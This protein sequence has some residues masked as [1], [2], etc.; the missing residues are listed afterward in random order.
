[1]KWQKFSGTLRDKKGF[2]VAEMM[3]ALG[4]FAIAMVV[5]VP[6]YVAFQPGMN[7]NGA[8][9]TILG[10]LM[11]AR[12][13]A[14]EQNNPYVVTFPSN[15]T[16]TILDDKNSDGS[17]TTGESTETINIGTEYPGVT[18]SQSGVDPTFNSRGT[19][20][21]STTITLSNSSGSKTVTVSGTGNVR[22]N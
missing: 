1:M 20:S 18:L 16:M 22:I 7:L 8:A 6:S 12:M 10:K 14:V 15:Q 21:G 13:K 17:A 19:A 11:W 2:T 9:R 3:A 5:A 4:V